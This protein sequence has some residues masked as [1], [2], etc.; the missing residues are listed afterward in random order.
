MKCVE[1][2]Y[3]AIDLSPGLFT[4]LVPGGF[5]QGVAYGS[6]DFG[7]GDPAPETTTATTKAKPTMTSKP[8]PSTTSTS[9]EPMSAAVASTSRCSSGAV[10]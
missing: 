3:A 6:W 10:A 4:Y 5:D 1:C 7:G 9:S 2:P 8:P